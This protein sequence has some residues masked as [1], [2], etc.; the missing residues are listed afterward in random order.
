MTCQNCGAPVR[1]DRDQGV[2]ICDYCGSQSTPPLDEDGVQVLEPSEHGCP[3]CHTPLNRGLVETRDLLYCTSCHGML[4]SMDEIMP[5]LEGLRSH[6][7]RP[8][9]YLAP[10]DRDHDRTL[11]CPL[12]GREM[13]RHAYGGGGNVMVDSCEDCSQLWLDRG[14]LRKIVIAPDPEYVYSNYESGRGEL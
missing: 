4:V 3:V 14:E 13:D 7:D 10:R 12:C 2:M 6:R 9:G 11:A 1:L 8:A 5:I